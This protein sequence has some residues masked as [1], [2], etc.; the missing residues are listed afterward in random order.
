MQI[1][2][3]REQITII[4]HIDANALGAVVGVY[5]GH[6]HEPGPADCITVRWHISKSEAHILSVRHKARCI[7]W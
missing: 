5:P 3:N 4:W 6:H 7:V 2:E 1:A